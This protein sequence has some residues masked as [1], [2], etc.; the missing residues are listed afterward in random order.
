MIVD[1]CRRV[2]WSFRIRMKEASE[3]AHESFMEEGTI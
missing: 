3:E 1:I 2:N